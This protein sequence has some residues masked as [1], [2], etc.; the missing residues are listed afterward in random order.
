MSPWA[1]P[2]LSWLVSLYFLCGFA[3]NVGF[4]PSRSLLTGDV[5][6]ICLWLL[7]LF[8]P[9]LKKIKIGTILEL[10]REVAQNK[11]ELQ[12]F[13]NE[14]RN[15]I[16]VLSTNVNTIGGMTNQVTVNVPS[17]AQLS[18]ANSTVDANAPPSTTENEVKVEQYLAMESG[19]ST[20]AL[21]RTRI[22]IERLLRTILGNRITINTIGNDPIKF[23]AAH[24][25][26]R[27]FLAQ[28]PEFDYLIKPFQYVNQVCNAAIHAQRV[29]DEHAQEALSL[30][31]KIIAVLT[32]F[33]NRLV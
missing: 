4:P 24:Q 30:G 6:F 14:I 32:E 26:F 16:S 18:E 2:V 19:D 31:A 12:E 25:L 1:L 20:M 28:N 9:F 22:E 27:A 23:A 5:F 11:K 21:A 10:E 3:F 7:F 8:L 17:L 13:K 29:S 33:E 15:I